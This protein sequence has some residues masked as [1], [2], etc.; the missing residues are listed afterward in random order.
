MEIVINQDLY[1]SLGSEGVSHVSKIISEKGILKGEEVVI[2]GSP[3]VPVPSDDTEV[4]G[5]KFGELSASPK[6]IPGVPGLDL[7]CKALCDSA[8]A[9]A[10]AALTVSGPALV[11]A[12]AAIA[13]AREECRK[14]C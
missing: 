13:A 8:A 1:D 7:V 4:F 12:L 2:K 6:F 3:D 11:A 9:A 14:R 5:L 10:A